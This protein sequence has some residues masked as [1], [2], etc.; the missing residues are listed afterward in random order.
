TNI[1]S[2][3]ECV[4]DSGKYMVYTTS[5]VISFQINDFPISFAMTLHRMKSSD[6]IETSIKDFSGLK[7]FTCNSIMIDLDNFECLINYLMNVER[8]KDISWQPLFKDP[9]EGISDIMNKRIV[10]CGSKLSVQAAMHT[11]KR[12]PNALCRIIRLIS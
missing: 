11:I 4:K 2:I 7:D 6:D 12:N 3:Y 1:P 8:L 9:L 10:F 5:A